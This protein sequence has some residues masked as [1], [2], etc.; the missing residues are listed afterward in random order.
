MFLLIQFGFF[1][2]LN[3]IVFSYVFSAYGFYILC[4]SC[5]LLCFYLCF[6]ALVSYVVKICWFCFWFAMFFYQACGALCCLLFDCHC[7]LVLS[8]CGFIGLLLCFA[9]VKSCVFDDDLWFEHVLSFVYVDIVCGCFRSLPL[10]YYVLFMCLVV[11]CV[12]TFIY[13]FIM[14]CCYVWALF[15]FLVFVYYYLLLCLSGCVRK[16]CCFLGL[17]VGQ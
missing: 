3:C 4:I 2:Y 15:G 11:C 16:C 10:F 6:L 14:C 5:V 9:N 12:V 13:L 1:I 17:F 8:A 7:G